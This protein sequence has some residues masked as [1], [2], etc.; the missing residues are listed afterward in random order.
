MKHKQ[1]VL[2]RFVG[3]CVGSLKAECLV[4]VDF[5]V[6]VGVATESATEPF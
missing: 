2:P 4:E 5:E 1:T 6:N 3:N